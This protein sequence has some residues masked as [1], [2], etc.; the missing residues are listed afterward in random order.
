MQ[1]D[2]LLDNAPCGYLVFQDNGIIRWVNTTLLTFLD[3]QSTQVIGKNIETLLT[4]ATRV[5]YN[6]HFFP[7]LKLHS[8]AD[9]IFLQFRTSG[10]I[11]LPALVNAERKQ[12]GDEYLNHCVIM[13]VHQR[14]KYEEEILLAKKQ[15]EH[16]MKE[17]HQLQELKASLEKNSLALES[18]Y[19]QQVAANESLLQFSKIISHD[20]QEPI[21]K[22][23]LFADRIVTKEKVS[24]RSQQDLRKI[25]KAA[26]RLRMLTRALEHY[27]RIDAEKSV[28]ELDLNK[29]I[30]KAETQAHE[31]RKVSDYELIV[32]HMP[33]IDGVEDQMTLLF[34]HL[35]DNAFQFRDPTRKLSIH[36]TAVSLDENLYRLSPNRYR[37]AEH[38]RITFRDNGIGFD[39]HYK[40][41]IFKILKRISPSDHGLGVGL[42]LIK[43]VVDNHAGTIEVNS[44]EGSGTTFTLTLP[45]RL[46]TM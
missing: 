18:L 25:D 17:N 33:L 32:D 7:L 34:F 46:H 23:Q 9:E 43:K 11:D 41:Y 2:R 44:I 4:L 36:I 39:M 31:Q 20:L 5:F 1:T 35:F 24:E 16:A 38:I 28:T 19:R 15:A 13:P 42:G 27:I 8:K 40:D 10:N 3:L 14:K 29:V 6:T 26:E 12:H 21:H 30:R 37:Y 22:I 45:R